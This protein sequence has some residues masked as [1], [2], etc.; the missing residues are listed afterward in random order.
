M[1]FHVKQ[2]LRSQREELV[3]SD[4]SIVVPDGTYA[5]ATPRS[6]LVV[7]HSIDVDAGVI[8]A[9]YKGLVEVSLFNHSDADFVID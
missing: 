5:R 6:G 4:L 2:G 9:D 1:T 8:D 7:K 3:S